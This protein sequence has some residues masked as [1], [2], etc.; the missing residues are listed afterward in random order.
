M[1]HPIVVLN[2]MGQPM[3]WDWSSMALA[4]ATLAG[5]WWLLVVEAKRR[6]PQSDDTRNRDPS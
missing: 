3:F 4:A 5:A 1:Q 6:A 2:I